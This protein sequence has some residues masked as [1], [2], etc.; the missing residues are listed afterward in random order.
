MK[1]E[2]F[3]AERLFPVIAMGLITAVCIAVVAGIY[4]STEDLVKMNETLFLKKAVL[5]AA[6]IDFPDE[7]SRVN[8][9]YGNRVRELSPQEGEGYYEILGES[10]ELTGYVVPVNGPGLWGEIEAVIGYEENMEILRGIEFVKQNETPGLGA[11]IT[12]PWFK[13]QF[14]GKQGPF[15]MVPEGSADG[16]N[17]LD[18]ITGA[19]RTSNFVLKLVNRGV[20]E[21][22]QRVKEGL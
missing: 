22:V 16:V 15:V 7:N 11:R 12:E 10:G 8:E 14:R 9:L 20:E 6:D 4:L 5:Y 19:T 17:E 13:E 21:A 1:K 18:A 3:F 2:G